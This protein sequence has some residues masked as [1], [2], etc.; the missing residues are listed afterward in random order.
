MFDAL[1]GGL[2][3]RAGGEVV[4]AGRSV[5]GRAMRA[6]RREPS[7]GEDRWVVVAGGQHPAEVPGAMG[8][9]A[10]AERLAELVAGGRAGMGLVVLPVIN[11]DGLAGGHWRF[12]ARGVD[13][14]R[15]WAEG[16][17]E[18]E[19]AVAAAF[20][21]EAT[22]GGR[23]GLFVDFHATEQDVFYTFPDE[24]EGGAEGLKRRWLDGLAR[25]VP[26][27]RV[28][29]KTGHNPGLAVS[30]LWAR[31]QWGGAALTFEF[32]D[33]TERGLIRRAAEAAADELVELLR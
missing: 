32:G 24:M 25:R 3:A 1:R 28:V 8:L 13:L 30:R 29:E 12:N 7:P 20:L 14:N 4:E 16:E 11:P 23:V 21:A 18:P 5:E 17:F 19:T 15:S 2:K 9:V 26:E 22:A 31:K 27:F 10:F 6:W 33:R